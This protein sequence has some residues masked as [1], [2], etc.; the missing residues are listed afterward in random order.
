MGKR[1]D[2]RRFPDYTRK[3]VVDRHME[4]LDTHG[5]SRREFRALASAGALAGATAAAMGVPAVAIAD[6]GG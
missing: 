5:V 4:A 2:P 3:S 1:L 6:Q